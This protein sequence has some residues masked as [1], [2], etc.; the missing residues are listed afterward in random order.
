[1]R[2][3]GD[4]NVD[5]DPPFLIERGMTK[6]EVLGLLQDRPAT[7]ELKDNIDE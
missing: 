7:S 3:I 1:L 2:T 5:P 6:V 4:S